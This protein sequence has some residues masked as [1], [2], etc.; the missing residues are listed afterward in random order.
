MNLKT[1]FTRLFALCIFLT[2][3]HGCETDQPPGVYQNDKI[4]GGL[5]DELH[6][7]DDK[8]FA[9]GKAN[10]LP[11]VEALLSREMLDNPAY[12]RTVDMISNNSKLEGYTILDEYYVKNVKEGGTNELKPANG[13]YN[14]GLAAPA[15][16]MYVALMVPNS[17]VD[18]WL[19]TAT[20]SKL[21]YG[22]K[23]TGLDISLY[24]IN[25]KTAPGLLTFAKEQ[26]A[27]GYVI[28]ALNNMELATKCLR[29]SATWTY[30][31]EKQIAD[32]YAFVANDAY[33]KY[34]YPIIIPIPSKPQIFRIMTQTQQG[35]GYVPTIRYLTKVNVHDTVA[36]K[37]E[38]ESIKTAVGK[39]LPGIDHD[40]PLVIFTAYNERPSGNSN[41]FSF[42][43]VYKPG[44]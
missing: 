30:A 39:A 20:C 29:P 31:N 10:D 17:K 18:K 27:K 33:R 14:F 21:D 19:I 23:I 24:A 8:L 35:G 13:S 16:E 43:M 44:H 1:F 36:V 15:R 34:Q 6:K 28:N 4:N 37:K 11:G 32:Y 41:P 25:G 40:N 3:L 9:A 42:D 2:V 38:F 12:K 5:R 22:W 7:L 26:Y